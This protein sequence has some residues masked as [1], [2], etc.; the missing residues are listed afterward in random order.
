MDGAI[1]SVTVPEMTTRSA[2]RGLAGR[3]IAEAHDVVAR[4]ERGTHLDGAAGQ[5][6]W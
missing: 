6:H 5:A 4:G 3:G 2:W 1:L